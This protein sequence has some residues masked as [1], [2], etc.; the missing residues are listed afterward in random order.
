MTALVLAVWLASTPP[1]AATRARADL[2]VAVTDADGAADV[3]LADALARTLAEAGWTAS[4]A[5]RGEC[6]DECVHVSV[7]K[8][9]GHEFLIEVRAGREVERV[10]VRVAPSASSFDQVN[11]LAI[12][13]EL[14]AARVRPP[15]RKQ[16]P[17]A[18]IA[19][20]QPA[21]A[22][23]LPEEVDPEEVAPDADERP[24]RMSPYLHSA[25]AV[26]P[27][28][29]AVPDAGPVLQAQVPVAP[30]E[31]RLAL[32]VAAMVLSDTAGNLFMHGPALG[33]RLRVT[34]RV[35][36]RVSISFLNEQDFNYQG[37]TYQLGMLPLALAAAVEIPGVPALRVGGGAEGLLIHSERSGEEAPLHWSI[38][39]I[40]RLEHRYAIR[41]FALMSSLQVALHPRSWN[42]A[43]NAGPLVTIP[44]WTLGAS[45][46]L[47]FKLF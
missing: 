32:N 40:A 4:P 3:A 16:A 9:D 1:A 21:S 13:A 45:L 18:V 31:E 34:H 2:R 8:L 6:G 39:P 27:A 44:Q 33:L 19:A 46:G 43:G 14:L 35:D 15:R 30:G 28:A 20:A 17:R 12:E 41:T 22:P 24:P 29:A 23:P 42:T 26:V 11:A 47:E 36:A 5:H 25:S 7:R 38:G 10:P 37:S